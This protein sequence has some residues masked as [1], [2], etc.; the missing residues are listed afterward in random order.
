[1]ALYGTWFIFLNHFICCVW[2]QALTIGIFPILKRLIK[3][4]IPLSI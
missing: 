2:E 4:K 3:Q 1:V